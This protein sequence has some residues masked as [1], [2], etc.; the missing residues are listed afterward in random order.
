M[1]LKKQLTK[2]IEEG[3]LDINELNILSCFMSQTKSIL[4]AVQELLKYSANGE[5]THVICNKF[6]LKNH[7]ELSV[8]IRK[9]LKEEF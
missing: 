3:L 7:C 8:K 5:T 9:K 1:D 2:V 6:S 4:L